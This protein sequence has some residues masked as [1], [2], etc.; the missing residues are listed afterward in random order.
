M[1][2][3]TPCDTDVAP[4]QRQYASPA[5]TSAKGGVL[6]SAAGQPGGSAAP[7]AHTACCECRW[8]RLA[9]PAR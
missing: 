2:A 4:P 1:R 8:I 6:S 5:H 7:S 3:L 9:D